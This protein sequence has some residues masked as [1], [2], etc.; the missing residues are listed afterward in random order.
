MKTEREIYDDNN[1]NAIAISLPSLRSNKQ[2]S[3]S[4]TKFLFQDKLSYHL[5]S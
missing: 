3:G 2:L 5:I 1:N 4:D